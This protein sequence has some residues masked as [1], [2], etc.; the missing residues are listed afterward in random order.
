MRKLGFPNVFPG[1]TIVKVADFNGDG[2]ADILSVTPYGL[3][4]V[5]LMGGE[6][7]VASGTIQNPAG[8]DWQIPHGTQ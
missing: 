2:R 4:S 6:K 8:S 5:W 7:I 1:S 3:A